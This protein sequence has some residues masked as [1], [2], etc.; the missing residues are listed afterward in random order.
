MKPTPP[1]KTQSPVVVPLVAAFSAFA[2]SWLGPLVFPFRLLT[3]IIHELSHGLAALLTGGAFV[4]F[5]VFADG[6]G[7]A[8]TA[9]GIRWI[10]IPAGYVGTALF[11]A[12]LITL[13]RSTKASRNALGILGVALLLL[14]LRYALPTV[15]SPEIIGGLLTLGIGILIGVSFLAIAWKLPTIWSLAMLN[16]IAFWVGLSALGDLRG[17]MLLSHFPGRSDAHAMA[18]I[19]FLPP[20]FWAFIWAIMSILALG[21]AVWSTW[22]QPTG[23]RVGILPAQ[24]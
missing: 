21:A 9:G 24:K 12:A 10:I 22:L 4:R 15:F 11:G 19:T 16:L 1:P 17:L 3:T 14:T 2:L 18:E 13:G 5:V 8:Y 6:S 20:I 7:L 23:A